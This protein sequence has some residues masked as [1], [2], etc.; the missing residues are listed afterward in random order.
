MTKRRQV[1]LSEES[2][3]LLEAGLADLRA[4]RVVGGMTFVEA[5][6]AARLVFEQL[7]DR[8]NEKLACWFDAGKRRKG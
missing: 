5:A 8:G 6:E 2:R 7:S 1:P 3:R 4:G